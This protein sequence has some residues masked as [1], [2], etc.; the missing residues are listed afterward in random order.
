MWELVLIAALLC[1]RS[2]LGY[3]GLRHAQLLLLLCASSHSLASCVTG[4]L[5]VLAAVRLLSQTE[6]TETHK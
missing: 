1:V 2:D 6:S 4:C 5:L 3:V